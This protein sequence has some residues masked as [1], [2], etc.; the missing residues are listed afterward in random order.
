MGETEY[1]FP[2]L[3]GVANEKAEVPEPFVARLVYPP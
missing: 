3:L 1:A 2:R